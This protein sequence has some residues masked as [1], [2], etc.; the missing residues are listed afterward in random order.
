MVLLAVLSLAAVYSDGD[1]RAFR[2]AFATVGWSYFLLVQLDFFAGIRSRLISEHLF[3]YLIPHIRPDAFVRDP[4]GIMIS[5]NGDIYE[6]CT[7][8]GPVCPR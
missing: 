8:I 6:R 5:V 1:R 2:I 3:G 7:G 4:R